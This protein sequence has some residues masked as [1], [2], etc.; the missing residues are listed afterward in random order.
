M[1]Q[2]FKKKSY[3]LPKGEFFLF[4]FLATKACFMVHDKHI[5]CFEG[6]NM[7]SNATFIGEN[8]RFHVV[9]TL[10]PKSVPMYIGDI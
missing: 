5:W 2:D 9:S 10:T 4:C 1:I 8:G 7:T 3:V 6:Y